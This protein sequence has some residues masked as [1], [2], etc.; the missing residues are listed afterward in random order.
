MNMHYRAPQRMCRP[1]EPPCG[2]RRKHGSHELCDDIW[3]KIGRVEFAAHPH[4]QRNGRIIMATGDVTAH[5]NHHHEDR[6]DGQGREKHL[7]QHGQR[8]DENEKK[9][10]DKLGE[11]PFHGLAKGMSES[12]QR[13]I[14][15]LTYRF[16]S[17]SAPSERQR[18]GRGTNR[19]AVKHA[20]SLRHRPAAAV[21]DATSID[22]DY[23]R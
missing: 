7:A 19:R 11:I 22:L 14:H 15:N 12:D 23:R 16:Q 3:D 20:Q 13:S 21:S 10:A 17:P 9:R 8:A 6:A 4:A 1:H 18:H 2:E 5:V